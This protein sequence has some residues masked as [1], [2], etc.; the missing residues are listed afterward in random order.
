VIFRPS[1]AAPTGL[2]SGQHAL[3]SPIVVGVIYDEGL[4]SVAK[5]K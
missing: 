4:R 2:L 3:F 5:Y 1:I